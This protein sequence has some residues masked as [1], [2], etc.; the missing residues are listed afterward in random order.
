MFDTERHSIDIP[1]P[2]ASADDRFT[3]PERLARLVLDS[4]LEQEWNLLEDLLHPDADLEVGWAGPGARVDKMRALDDAWAVGGRGLYQPEYEVVQSLDADTA[5]VAVTIR[6]EVGPGL[7]SER[8]AAYLM[9]FKDG[10]LLRN[11]I[12]NSVEEALEAHRRTAA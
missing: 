2:A 4:F 3:S 11:R 10:L 7:H 12:F 1:R 9:T 5:L 6:Y 8:S